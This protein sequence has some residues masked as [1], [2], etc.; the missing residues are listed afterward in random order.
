M[1]FLRNVFREFLLGLMGLLAFSSAHALTSVSYSQLQL[2]K[3]SVVV[4]SSG[5]SATE[6]IVFKVKATAVTF[7]DTVT[8]VALREVV[9]T[10]YSE[11]K[12]LTFKPTL[13]QTGDG[14]IN[15][16]RSGTITWAFA[17]GKH[18]LYL[19]TTTYNGYQEDSP[20]LTLTV[21][22]NS[23]PKVT[24]GGPISGTV[25]L[26]TSSAAN[27]R[28]TGTASDVD[29]NFAK[30]ELLDGGVV[31]SAG[32]STSTAYDKTVSL[33]IGSHTLQLRA[34]DSMS[35]TGASATTTV[36]VK[37]D[38]APTISVSAPANN[39]KIL[40]NGS[41]ASVT[42]V[43]TAGDIDNNFDRTE[44][45]VDSVVQT[46][47]SVTT[48]AY[49]KSIALAVGAHAIQLRSY[50][51]LGKSTTS[52]AVNVT[53][54]ANSNPVASM[55][56]PANNST[57]SY[58]SGSSAT[59]TVTGS[60]S[61]TDTANGD[62]IKTIEIWVDGVKNKTIT[63]N[64]VSSSVSFSSAGDHT[65]K[66]RAYDSF[67]DYDD[68]AIN[69]VKV[70][71]MGPMKGTV[72]DVVYDVSGQPMLKGWACDTNV[73]TPVVVRLFAGG[74]QGTGTQVAET[75][76]NLVAETAVSQ[77]CGTTAKNY[78]WSFDLASLQAAN[79]GKTLYVYGVSAKNGGAMTVLGNGGV[80]KVPAV[81]A[82]IPVQIA[83]PHIGNASA[84]SLDDAVGVGTSG[85]ATYSLQIAVPPGSGGMAPALGLNY[86]SQ[87]ANGVMGVGW[88]INGL[89]S[90]HR[91]TKTL[92]QDGVTGR[93]RFDMGDRLCLDGQRLVRVNGA[94]PGGTE[95]AKDSAYWAASGEYRTEAES[96]A[97]ITA[98][99]SGYKVERKGGRVEYYGTTTSSAI[100]ATG[101]SDNA[102]LAWALARVE[103]RS[104]NYY[105]VDYNQ[106]FATNGEYTAKQIRYG[107]N[108]ANSTAADL[109]VRFVYETRPDGQQLYVGGSRNDLASRLTHVQTF[110]A[111]AADGTG[112]KLVRDYTVAYKQ[113]VSSNRS[114]V[115][116]IQACATN[117]VSQAL[118]CLPKTTFEWGQKALT[119]VAGTP[120]VG[121]YKY[122]GI[123]HGSDQSF[124]AD[125]D[126]DGVDEVVFPGTYTYCVPADCK[127]YDEAEIITELTGTLTVLPNAAGA[128]R[129]I[130]MSFAG[131]AFPKAS[132]TLVGDLN[133]DGLPDIVL[134]GGLVVPEPKGYCLNNGTDAF[135]C[136]AFPEVTGSPPT[137]VT[138]NKVNG[139]QLIDFQNDRRAHVLSGLHHH[140]WLDT[141]DVMRY[142]FVDA[143]NITPDSSGYRN[144]L[145]IRQQVTALQLSAR[146]VS[147]FYGVGDNVSFW[148]GPWSVAS[149][150]M[151]R[152]T[153]IAN[154]QRFECQTIRQS[155]TSIGSVA[156]VGDLNG[157]GLTDFVIRGDNGNFVTCVSTETGSTCVDSGVHADDLDYGVSFIGDF[158][159]DG[160]TGMLTFSS[161][162]HDWNFDKA[163]WCRLDSSQKLQCTAVTYPSLPGYRLVGPTDI[164]GSQVQAILFELSSDLHMGS[165][166]QDV[167]VSPY[168]LVASDAQDRLT[169]V[170]GG[171]GLRRE[172]TYTRADDTATIRRHALVD[173]VEQKPTY[174]LVETT[175]GPVVKQMK[176]SNG[177]GGWL[178]FNYHYEGLATDALGRGSAG[179]AVTRTTDAQSGIATTQY[180]RQDYPYS[181]SPFRTTR[182]A[183]NGTVLTDTNITLSAKSI[184]KAA[185]GSYTQFIIGSP[186]VTVAR[187]LDGNSLGTTT[188]TETYGDGWGNLTYRK[189]DVWDEATSFVSEVTSVFQND[190][191]KW[192]IGL[193]TSVTE[194]R[195][196]A[197]KVVSAPRKT[198]FTYNL[199]SGLPETK[200]V[201]PDVAKY[202]VVTTFDR[203][204]NVYG[205]VN[206]GTDA[207]TDPYDST[208]QSRKVQDVVY[209]A[210]G[211]FPTTARNALGQ[212]QS[213]VFDPG[214]GQ[215]TSQ[216]DLN[217][218]TTTWVI[219]GF[220]RIQSEKHADGGE[221]RHY[222]VQ[223]DVDCPAN[224]TSAEIVDN[225]NGTSRTT[226][227]TVT[228]RDAASH[229][230]NVTS[231]GF[232]GLPIVQ[233]MRYDA[234]GRLYETDHPR[235]D[236]DSAY[237]AERRIYDALN[238]VTT[239]ITL[240]EDGSA[241]SLVTDYSGLTVEVTNAKTQK[242]TEKRDLLGRVV[243]VT[244]VT[245]QGNV[246]TEFGY[247]AF[248][249][250]TSTKDPNGNFITVTFDDYGRKT[251]LKDPDLGWIHYDVDP[252]GRTWKQT[253]PKQRKDVTFTRSVYDMLDRLVDRFEPDLQSHWIYDTATKGIGQLAEAYT[254]PA[255]AKDYRRQHGF[256][257]L[258]R[259][260]TTTI[261]LNGVAYKSTTAYDSWSR[262][263]TLTHQRGSDA[264]K[265]YGQRYNPQ[266][267]LAAITR[268]GLDLW[269]LIAQDAAKRELKSE[270]GNGLIH[271]NHYDPYTARID[272]IL[273]QMGASGVKRFHE[274]NT[275][276][277]LGNVL[278]RSGQFNFGQP[279]VQSYQDTFGYDDLNRLTSAQ[280]WARTA[281]TFGYD[282]AGLLKSKNDPAASITANY[283]YPTN[284]VNSVRPHAVKSISGWT[285]DFSYDD[286]GNM[287]TSP[288]GLGVTWT[289]FDMPQLI[290]KVSGGVTSSDTFSYGAE[291]QRAKLVKNDGSTIY[292]AGAF[293][294][295]TDSGGTVRSIKTYWPQG[296]GVEID[297]PSVAT[298][299]RWT[300]EDRLGSTMAIT[301]TTGS[302]V[303][304]LNY[305][306]WGKRRNPNGIGTP[307]TLAG[308][309]DNKGFT[310]HEMLDNVDLVHMNGRIYDPF[311][312]RFISADI[313]IQDPYN[314]QNYSRYS[315]V[316]NNPTN[317]TDP[318]GFA[319]MPVESVT[320]GQSGGSKP[321]NLDK[322]LDEAERDGDV[323]VVT[324]ADGKVVVLD[325]RKSASNKSW[326]A[327][328]RFVE[329]TPTIGPSSANFFVDTFAG[330]MAAH[331]VAPFAMFTK[332][333]INPLTGYVENFN[334]DK[335]AEA[336]IGIVTLGIGSEARAES[337]AFKEL[338]VLGKVCGCCFVAGT[339][340]LVEKGAVAID[341]IQVGQL[342]QARDELT[343]ATALKQVTAVI[344]NEGRP[345]FA[346]TLLEPEGRATRVEVSADHPFWVEGSG[347]V[348]AERLTRGMKIAT[349]RNQPVTV[350]NLESLGRT[351]PTF[352][353]TVD[354]YHT[355]FVG[356]SA[357]FVHNA[358][359]CCLSQ[360]IG[361]LGRA[362]SQVMRQRAGF[363]AEGRPIILDENL[364]AKGMAEALR[365]LGHNVRTVREIFGRGGILDSKILELAKALNAKVLT[366][367][368]GRQLDGGFFDRAI[369]VDSRVRSSEGV[370]R[371]LEEGLK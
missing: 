199:T 234:K 82:P 3:T 178:S 81:G 327:T 68:S 44:L 134:V 12:T 311:V 192:L 272:D 165:D 302:L 104:G 33:A 222:L 143:V 96:F 183:S 112:G 93:I 85:N 7:S 132:S 74:P 46:G 90:I 193:P 173:G 236:T 257:S 298:A 76:A 75:M 200:T 114:L 340:V 277:V 315:Y 153:V 354:D 248:G 307:D 78:R 198:T 49:S 139:L 25:A 271:T 235:F 249:N 54:V 232:N 301:D 106:N 369:Q 182:I 156:T 31:N 322:T 205:L 30:T 20:Q 264:A 262:V 124:R 73:T 57:A 71:V 99:G 160:Y 244:N 363:S 224:A 283:T 191:A 355:F 24:W 34:T 108:T 61:D 230:L 26:T 137:G 334:G 19:R 47:Y 105:T 343:G 319:Q 348:A 333:N 111:T 238:R 43:G 214:S 269:Q 250:L 362:L 367:D 136:K 233:E 325:L 203:S 258:G 231:W 300:H 213:Q 13:D 294:V 347:W 361:D 243:S 133:G 184:T 180:F 336:F 370:A 215:K 304:T 147:D 77:A 246:V 338:S 252:V 306:A 292:Y 290:Q 341:E 287:L 146:D 366:R 89:S 256:D 281:K 313:L 320:E 140:F 273:V 87:G 276:D 92:A 27:V 268:A 94:A 368:V 55:T 308:N 274:A 63:G 37:A 217:G 66:L 284:G 38:T 263:S 326:S 145:E 312:G 323:I 289:S 121:H 270:Y 169:A 318:T 58:Y 342:V 1:A 14:V 201:S 117:P 329:Q 275:F 242:R 221:T 175:S 10:S 237:L 174:P 371:I 35:Q 91:C 103:D 344:R 225:F 288:T 209:D 52:A 5:D 196:G 211:R 356:E 339:P 286:N 212:P 296:V 84:G 324:M 4:A 107:G 172:L 299:L 109:A 314:G 48:A 278:T 167:H 23:A 197:G 254:G 194:T 6:G 80:E 291:H 166:I 154:T 186:S 360:A 239:L 149:T 32:T 358:G 110:I 17:P 51:D 227:P 317:L 204:G 142:Q 50:D 187:D 15:E 119:F 265:V 83:P 316:L 141:S 208:T 129:T 226:V 364:S 357:S 185:D 295:E 125:M 102:K 79:A 293:E 280:E 116:S 100:L 144:P 155:N 126:G 120:Y 190:S 40:T 64:T 170:V 181:G 176:T 365:A 162:T 345:I 240:K 65:V 98:S 150:C 202:K 138:S 88:S 321:F 39:A 241:A 164:D 177:Q 168:S 97:R 349:F 70:S 21:T 220:G 267:Y 350:V 309:V 69:T 135:E 210:K 337:A 86:S 16:E 152:P 282:A 245:S 72:E 255:T 130:T 95:A 115:D 123:A 229:V 62:S 351:Q 331:I 41:T 228:Y 223:C 29:G 118:E 159:G 266:G 171:A 206:T 163:K 122:T 219:D 328:G 259:P 18:I 247:D 352:N 11:W 36:T 127:P 335:R 59:V 42:V 101:R 195:T 8:K 279:D 305:D 188:V 353:L 303:E 148:N 330:R 310:G 216:T 359:G 53:V 251:D 297:K 67:G 60:A 151:H 131:G 179:F 158:A 253:S 28:I 128:S 346:L 189:T 285:G 113:S 332:D 9:N 2:T 22:A 207:W 260:S 157:D 56:A 161:T 218:R 261:T 45:L